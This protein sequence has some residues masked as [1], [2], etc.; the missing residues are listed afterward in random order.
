LRI[1]ASNFSPHWLVGEFGALEEMKARGFINEAECSEDIQEVE[2]K[3]TAGFRT[4][5]D[6]RAKKTKKNTAQ[7]AKRSAVEEEPSE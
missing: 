3:L 4:R 7:S 2:K 5:K 1:R 6:Q